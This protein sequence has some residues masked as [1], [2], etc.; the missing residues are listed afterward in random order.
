MRELRTRSAGIAAI[1]LVF[2]LDQATKL[3]A[4]ETLLRGEAHEVLP[5]FNLRLSF[6]EGISFSLFTETFAGR[7]LVLASVTFIVTGVLAVLLLRSSH[8]LEAAA[9]GLII[10]GALGNIL[11]RLRLGAVVDFLDFHW[12]DTHWP[13]FNLADTAIVIGA[14]LLVA[15]VFMRQAPAEDQKED[16]R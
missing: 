4:L 11:D 8:R 14:V 5:F 10:G 3:F 16:L 7:P 1:V 13:A 15:S 9:L 6:N 12:R 2:V